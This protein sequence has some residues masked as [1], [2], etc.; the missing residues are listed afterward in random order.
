M[1]K[2]ESAEVPVFNDIS[3]VLETVEDVRRARLKAEESD[4]LGFA[5]YKGRRY[6]EKLAAQLK[7][8]GMLRQGYTVSAA[9]KETNRSRDTFYDWCRGSTK[10]RKQADDAMAA[11]QRTLSLATLDRRQ[12]DQE[13]EPVLRKDYRT[14]AEY[15]VAFRKV[16]FGHDT[17][18]HIW[19]ALEAM[20]KAPVGGVTE[21]LF[22]PE[23]GKTTL[24][25]D[26]ICADFCDDPNTRACFISGSLDFTVKQMQKIQRRLV[27]D[28]APTLMM[29]HFGP[30]APAS[31]DSAKKWNSQE[32]TLAASTHDEADPS[33]GTYGVTGNIRGTRWKRMYLD[34]IQSLR[35]KNETAKIVE[36][37]RGDIVSRLIKSGKLFISG[38]RVA[39]NDVY[40]EFERLGLLDEVVIIPA[41]DLS[42]PKGS[43]SYFPPQFKD[44]LPILD[45]EG[46]QL[47]F[48]D[49][50]MDKRRAQLGEDQW[51]RVYMMKPMSQF[52]AMIT[53]SDIAN[54]TDMERPVGMT[55]KEAVANI[56]SLDPSL[57]NYAP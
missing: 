55:P 48:S 45:D 28:G 51:S 54:A 4:G 11:Y 17:F 47:G 7:V 20:E 29:Q 3:A 16:Y 42:K 6:E 57:A 43:Q 15:V 5:S 12:L 33:V 56:A 1:D 53:E 31:R 39:K 40:E 49:E 2:P 23:A 18:E 14:W 25:L 22:P 34:D 37:F 8:L 36:I 44:G 38:S 30:F 9:M 26:I 19:L 32:I 46:D 10:F 24:E 35:T 41:M 27:T 21:I 50:Y 13:V 52:S